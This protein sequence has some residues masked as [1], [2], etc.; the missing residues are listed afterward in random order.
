MYIGFEDEN[1]NGTITLRPMSEAFTEDS[2]FFIVTPQKDEEKDETLRYIVQQRAL[3]CIGIKY[4]YHMK[5]VSCE[6]F[7]LMMLGIFEESRAAVQDEILRSHKK[8]PTDAQNERMQKEWNSR[9]EIFHSTVIGNLK[10]VKHGVFLTLK[11]LLKEIGKRNPGLNL[12]FEGSFMPQNTE[13]IDRMNEA[14]EDLLTAVSNNNQSNVKKLVDQG[15]DL[16]SSTRYG[17]TALT[18]AATRGYNDICLTLT[19]KVSPTLRA[20][21]NK[22]DEN[23]RNAY[24]YALYYGHNDTLAVFQEVDKNCEE[25]SEVK[26]MNTR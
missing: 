21:P 23:Q 11:F 19:S 26:E 9:Y 14:Y 24:E 17:K 18:V 16:N 5:A 22:K 3:A 7:A 2:L 12:R 4:N 10:K 13:F 15:L 1:C 20:N 6:S 8:N 25:S